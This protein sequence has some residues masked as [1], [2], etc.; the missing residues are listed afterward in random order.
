MIHSSFLHG[1]SKEPLLSK[2]DYMVVTS[3]I[4][5]AMLGVTLF[6]YEQIS[7]ILEHRQ[8]ETIITYLSIGYG[9]TLLLSLMAII[10]VNAMKRRFG[11]EKNALIDAKEHAELAS[12]EQSRFL[13][14]IIDNA[15]DGV[16]TISE[17]AI[18]ET[19]NP[20]CET[21]FGYTA[22]E[23]IGQPVTM[24]MPAFYDNGYSHYH[25]V[26]ALPGEAKDSGIRRELAGKRK[27]GENFT[28]DISI[29]EVRMGNRRVFS[30]IMR[31]ISERKQVEERLHNYTVELEKARTEAERATLLKSE[32]LANMSHEIRTPMNGIIGMTSLLLSSS[33]LSAAELGYVE[34]IMQSAECMLTLMNDILDLSKIEA[35]KIELEHT[36]FD[37]LMLCEDVCDMMM[38]RASEK[39]LELLLN[40]PAHTPR[41]VVGDPGRVRQILLNLVSN[42]IKFT[43]QGNI[44]IWVSCNTLDKDR[45][46][47]HVEVRDTGIGI[48]E[49]KLDYIFEKFAQ[50]DEST[51]RKFGGSGLG[52]AICRDL[53][54]IMQGDIGVRSKQ[55]EGSAFWFKI[56]LER[57]TEQGHRPVS[58]PENASLNGARVLVIDN[59]PA[60]RHILMEQLTQMHC[61]VTLAETAKEALYILETDTSFDAAIVDYMMPELDGEELGKRIKHNPATQ[62]IS[63]LMITSA[64]LRGDSQRIQDIGFSGYLSKPVS[65]RQLQEALLM[66]ISARKSGASLP[67]ITQHS[68]REHRQIRDTVP[69]DGVF[70][71]NV[72]VLL[73]EDNIV[74]QS[75]AVKM[76]ELCGCRVTIVNSGK[77]ALDRIEHRKFDI[78][79][80]DC[81]MP[82][83][84]GYKATR[85]IRKLEKSRLCARIPVIAFT[86]NALKGDKEKCIAAGMDDCLTKPISIDKLKQCLLKWLPADKRAPRQNAAGET[87]PKTMRVSRVRKLATLDHEVFGQLADIVGGDLATLIETH[88]NNMREYVTMIKSAFVSRNFDKLAQAAHAIKSSNASLGAIGTFYIAQ[89]LELLARRNPPAI[90]DVPGLIEQL[91]EESGKADAAISQRMAAS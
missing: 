85:L 77:D 12:I 9:L 35:G 25:E 69:L 14:S 23:A 22:H 56:V 33:K 47:F 59:N 78:V 53:T 34:T 66:M 86:A 46:E 48:P 4:V 49:D 60:V 73:A 57:N 62:H 11:R 20:A 2:R 36:P 6:I 64:P 75:V 55:G 21:M 45:L 61:T 38:P 82:G 7:H 15:A 89:K 28:L 44:A 24:L 5:T 17:T 41:D 88:R 84:D 74:N 79:L 31:D 51:T 39:K 91:E 30:A 63:L 26:C 1:F 18:V 29:S 50:A 40:Y 87:M 10:I 76:L 8:A 81:Q 90:E 52:L 68:L 27:N 58:L 70:F 54:R 16:M 72:H 13:A 32:F 80:M 65:Y 43:Q 71:Q 67:L 3:I 19:Y 42:A 37:L 83:M